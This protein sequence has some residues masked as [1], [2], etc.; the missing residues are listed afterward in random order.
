L[1]T[2]RRFDEHEVAAIFERATARLMESDRSGSNSEA[3]TTGLTL[4][5]LQRI[6]GE[7]GIPPQLIEECA[8]VIEA[9]ARP[10]AITEKHFGLP[11]R[12]SGAFALPRDLT[13]REWNELVVV[14]RETFDAHGTVSG[15]G[16]LRSW[17]DGALEIRLEPTREGQR[18]HMETRKG[19]AVA[20]GTVGSVLGAMGIG[21]GILGMVSGKPDLAVV[22]P[23]L[24]GGMGATMFGLGTL[25]LPRW[26]R[27]RIDQMNRVASTA[28]EMIGR[29]PKEG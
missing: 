22:M 12:V 9:G 10:V 13:D 28:M 1:V 14:L 26:G 18:L 29:A 25:T 4:T 17:R 7:V 21:F 15:E 20:L 27:E 6:G 8:A 19:D 3:L 24:L 2:E 16:A 5:E 11:A 23:A